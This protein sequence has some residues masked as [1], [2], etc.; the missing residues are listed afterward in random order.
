MSFDFS[1]LAAKYA[2]FR[3][4]YPAALLE[5][6]GRGDVAWDAGC[7]SGQ[8]SVALAARYARVIAT[9]PAQAQLDAAERHPRVEYRRAAAEAGIDVGVELA[10]AA[11]AAHWF[12]WPAYVAAVD[13]CL[14]PGGRAAVVSYG[15]VVVPGAAGAALDAF[16]D[17]VLLP[18]WPAE[19]A[20]VHDGYARL[21]WPAAWTPVALPPLAMEER[22]T[23]DEFVGYLG[24]WSAIARFRAAHGP[25]AL[26]PILGALAATWPAD[27]VRPIRWPLVVKVSVR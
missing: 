4:K 19:R 8:L 24:T 20:H 11:Q 21:R 16:Y 5:A 1:A 2:A 9:D 22:W 6:L 17:D 12:D 7:G 3:P 23:R 26:D 18:Y 25:A 27:E 15:R 14:R 13:H 10:V